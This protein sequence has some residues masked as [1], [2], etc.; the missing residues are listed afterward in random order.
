[1]IRFIR[2]VALALI[3]FPSAEKAQDF[4]AGLAAHDAHD[5]ATELRK[6]IALAKQGDATAQSDLGTAYSN[7]RSLPRD[8]AEAFK[9]YR[10]AAEQGLAAAQ[11]NLGVMYAN[12]RGVPQDHAEAARWYRLAAAQGVAKAHHSLG[13]MYAN[14]QGVPQDYMRAHM[15]LNLG[16][17][18]GNR[19][20]RLKDRIAKDMTPDEIFEAQRRAQVCL[21][22][23]YQDCDWRC[24]VSHA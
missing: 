22:S 17:A 2:K 15:W 16:A 20:N 7:G 12:S 21:A 23:N 3:R 9:W 5:L 14:G 18:N 19:D 10:L 1:M 4:D 24:C 6:L 13:V 8:Y 11:F